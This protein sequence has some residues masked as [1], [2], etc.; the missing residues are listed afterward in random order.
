[1]TALV[2]VGVWCSAGCGGNGSGFGEDGS[3][4][5]TTDGVDNGDGGFGFGDVGAESMPACTGLQCQVQNCGGGTHT[6]VSGIVYDPA[7]RNPLYNVYVYVPN[8]PVQPIT[9]GAV[10]QQ[11]QAPASGSP[12]P[13]AVQTDA[14]GKF[15]VTDVP[16]GNN[17]PLVMQA[18]K[19]RRQIIIPTVTACVN[20]PIGQKDV[21]N[22]ET[23]TRLPRKQNEGMNN[24]DNLPQLAMA[25]GACDVLE[26]LMRK[27]GI[28]D[29]EFTKTGRVHLF[30]GQGGV[31]GP[32]DA[33]Y[34]NAYAFWADSTDLIAH[35][36]VVNSCECSPYDRDSVGLAYTAM[37]TYLD[38]GGRLF[39]THYHYN[40]FAPPTG[41]TDFQGTANWLTN[42]P[43]ASAPWYINTTIPKGVAFNTWIQNVWKAAPPA[44]GQINLVYSNS[45]ASQV[46]GKTTPWIYYGNANLSSNAYGTAYLSFDT[47]ITV[48]PPAVQCGRAVFSDLHVSSGGGGGSTFPQECGTGN[49]YTTPMT[50]QESALEFLFFDLSSCV[51][52]DNMPPPPPPPN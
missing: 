39:G 27:I 35:D 43:F 4:D 40:W 15:T 51:T 41:P 3:A 29:S 24:V 36:I 34:T 48:N 9:T 12:L 50:Q 33:K 47:P 37:H 44:N 13:G 16:V 46:K 11:C 52:D 45:D 22:L 10:C 28:D 25:T 23:I 18:G 21:N 7:G 14:Y 26:C 42:S 5:T 6:T 8:A 17:I 38:T 30:Q 20:N 31:T 32:G 19:F 1:M 49:P 2:A